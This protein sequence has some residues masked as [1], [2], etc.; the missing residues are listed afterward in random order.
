MR[1]MPRKFSA[2]IG[3]ATELVEGLTTTA[4]SITLVAVRKF[5]VELYR[6]S[7]QPETYVR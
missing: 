2:W 6:L 1:Q 7:M 5:R 4:T 3:N